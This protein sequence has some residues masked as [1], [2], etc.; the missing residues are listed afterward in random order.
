LWG[1]VL[2]IP[3]PTDIENNLMERPIEKLGKSSLDEV[4][5]RVENPTYED[6]IKK[7]R[8]EEAKRNLNISSR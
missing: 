3:Y 2:N 1:L 5:K 8:K 6:F 7:E 4:R